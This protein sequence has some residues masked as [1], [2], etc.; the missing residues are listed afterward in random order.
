[1][2]ITCLGLSDLTSKQSWG[3]LVFL[4]LVFS[5]MMLRGDTFL[6]CWILRL[7]AIIGFQI[8]PMAAP[9]FFMG[10]GLFVVAHVKGLNDNLPGTTGFLD[11][12]YSVEG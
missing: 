10:G 1:V 11:L 3:G 2:L 12:P 4:V 9:I 6:E 8:V 7:R 5:M